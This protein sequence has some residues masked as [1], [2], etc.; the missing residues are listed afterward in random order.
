MKIF[1]ILNMYNI[2]TE[3]LIKF[4]CENENICYTKYV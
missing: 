1:V 4:L 2:H 3:N